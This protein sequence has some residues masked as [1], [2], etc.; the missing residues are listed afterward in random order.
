MYHINSKKKE[1]S[2]VEMSNIRELIFTKLQDVLKNEKKAKNIEIS[3]YNW[4]I[5]YIKRNKIEDFTKQNKKI[6]EISWENE[7]FRKM[8]SNKCRSILFN[9]KNEKN[10]EF[11]EKVLTSEIKSNDLVH[12]SAQEIFPKLWEPFKQ[13][14]EEKEKRSLKSQGILFESAVE[15]VYQCRKCKCRKIDHYGV[16]TRSADEPMTTYFTCLGCYHRWKD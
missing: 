12:M 1:L 8:Y 16:Q 5:N 9:L 11:L 7:R 6:N 14:L 2:Q 10:P 13:N 4:T 3:I 15:G